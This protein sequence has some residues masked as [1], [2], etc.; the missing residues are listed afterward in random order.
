[1]E[2]FN[3]LNISEQLLTNLLGMNY[4]IPTPV[5]AQ[6]IPLALSGKDILGT[7]QTGTGK[8]GAYGVPLINHL[9]TNPEASALVLAPTRELAVQVLKV[10]E[11]MLG[12]KTNIKTALIIGGDPIAKQIDQLARGARLIVGTPGRMND[13][14]D[15]K[16]INLKTTNFVVLD[17][18][19][20]MLDMGFEIQIEQVFKSLAKNKQTLMF[21]ATMPNNILKIAQK[22]LKDEE[23]IAVGSTVSAVD[24]IKQEII[25]TSEAEKHDL[26]LDQLKVNTGSCIIFVKTKIATEKL[27]TRLREYGHSADAIHGD[28]R[29][30]NREKV[31]R[32]FRNKKYRILVATDVAARGIDIPHIEHV[33]NYDLPQ[34]EEDFIHRIGR[35]GRAGSIG[36]AVSFITPQDFEKW[37]KICKMMNLTSEL[38]QLGKKK[39]QESR[40]SKRRN[41]GSRYGANSSNSKQ[42]RFRTNSFNS[43]KPR[44]GENSSSSNQPRF[45][46]EASPSNQ[47]RFRTNSSSSNKSRF[48]E[49]SS[50]LNQPRFR[51]EASPSNQS[52]FRTN[53]SSSN[54][55]RFGAESSKPKNNNQGNDSWRSNKNKNF[56]KP[57]QQDD[58][59]FKRRTPKADNSSSQFKSRRVKQNS[60]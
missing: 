26:L 42:S 28:L 32:F 52:K 13:H 38:D 45:R 57:S 51:S 23:R 50:S 1:M 31:L 5:Q 4:S 11:Q 14:I 12:K 6:T 39:I 36:N 9:M 34:C 27:A 10:L 56:S 55:S 37:Y 33:V 16:S 60:F 48:G 58:S 2:N 20:R 21:S 3:S 44:F 53:S 25:K 40:F 22:Y 49:S 46:S 54:Q 41:N 29:Q 30:R 59:F 8:T 43:N 17:E 24:T 47:S 15:R 18:M 7:A 19:D 35:T